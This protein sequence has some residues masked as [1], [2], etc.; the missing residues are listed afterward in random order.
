MPSSYDAGQNSLIDL[1]NEKRAANRAASIRIGLE[2][3]VKALEQRIEAFEAGQKLNDTKEP[4][5]ITTN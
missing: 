1:A 3:R 2:A 4:D 5:E